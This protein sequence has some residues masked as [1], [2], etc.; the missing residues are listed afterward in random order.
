MDSKQLAIG[1]CDEFGVNLPAWVNSMAALR[2]TSSSC[3]GSTGTTQRGLDIFWV[4]DLSFVVGNEDISFSGGLQK[5]KR[6]NLS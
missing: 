4:S 2:S 6:E 1:L 3:S 5:E